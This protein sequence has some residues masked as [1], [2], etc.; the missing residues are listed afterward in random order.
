MSKYLPPKLCEVEMVI[1]VYSHCC[2]LSGF[3]VFL[4]LLHMKMKLLL[5]MVTA[6]LMHELH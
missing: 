1:F 4:V 5:S 3:S 6:P 2:C